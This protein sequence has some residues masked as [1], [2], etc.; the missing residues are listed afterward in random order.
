M[1]D[2][3]DRRY[4]TLGGLFSSSFIVPL[5]FADRRLYLRFLLQRNF[6]PVLAGPSGL[7]L[8]SLYPIHLDAG[9]VFAELTFEH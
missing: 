2:E 4:V 1:A 8:S 5:Y 7:F 9:S 3:N 6:A